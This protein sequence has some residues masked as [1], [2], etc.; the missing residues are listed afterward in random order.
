VLVKRLRYQPPGLG[1][2][3]PSHIHPT[4]HIA[5][6]GDEGRPEAA[7]WLSGG[8]AVF[9]TA[10]AL[11]QAKVMLMDVEG[12]GTAD[13]AARK[14]R[15]PLERW[16]ATLDPDEVHR[17]LTESGD[18]RSAPSFEWRDQ[19][20]HLVFRAVPKK[21]DARGS[22]DVRPLGAFG[23]GSAVMV[24]DAS[25]LRKALDDKGSAYGKLPYPLV[26]A[27]RTSSMTAD[28]FDILNVLYGTEQVQFA[29]GPDGETA[30]RQF[31][32]SDGYWFGGTEWRHRHVSGVLV[33][34][35]LQP[36]T[37]SKDA[38]ML[39]EHPDPERPVTAAPMWRRAVTTSGTL[40]YIDPAVPAHTLFDLPLEWPV[41]DP[42]DPYPE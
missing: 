17:Q 33:A 34:N 8:A 37:V 14:L 4:S 10:A 6:S 35:G 3:E 38:P 18:I 1:S 19:D 40:E 24:D 9:P 13:L 21:P 29:I 25:P 27:V 15:T 5:K 16:L 28:E 22:E 12:E 36:W 11:L 26:I 39:W 41:G 32:A 2:G 31:R 23:Q 7:E 20:W 30:T 42:F